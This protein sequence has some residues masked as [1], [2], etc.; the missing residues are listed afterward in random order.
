MN[1]DWQIVQM[2]LTLQQFLE[3]GNA[4][5]DAIVTFTGCQ[6][7]PK[8]Q[9]R[10]ICTETSSNPFSPIHIWVREIN[11]LP[12]KERGGIDQPPMH[13]W[14][15]A[16][17]A[18]SMSKTNL[19]RRQCGFTAAAFLH[20]ASLLAAEAAAFPVITRRR[21]RRDLQ[22]AVPQTPS[23]PYHPTTPSSHRT[24]RLIFVRRACE[25]CPF[26]HVATLV[27][28]RSAPVSRGENASGTVDQEAERTRPMRCGGGDHRG[29]ANT[30][31]QNSYIYLKVFSLFSS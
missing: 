7:W 18:W 28:P 8:M 21:R 1:T 9:Q 2:I 3:K 23:R 16:G 13:H 26:A 22:H 20:L 15:G 6:K 14:G 24:G 12:S 25:L 27:S 10:C 29:G 31:P 11:V 4:F 17:G 5:E 30:W 19:V